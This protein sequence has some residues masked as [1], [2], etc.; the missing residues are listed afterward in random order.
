MV[1]NITEFIE[2]VNSINRLHIASETRTSNPCETSVY[3][4]N[5]GAVLK[6]AVEAH[7]VLLRLIGRSLC[8]TELH[9]RFGGEMTR[10][11]LDPVDDMHGRNLLRETVRPRMPHR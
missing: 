5:G 11:K 8:G 6:A 3:F 2:N 7:T 1:R 9:F 10:Q 4:V